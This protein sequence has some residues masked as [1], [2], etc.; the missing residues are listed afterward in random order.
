M[1]IAVL[2]YAT[3]HRKTYDVLCRLKAE[4]YD[5]V[6]VF[7]FPLTYQ[8]KVLPTVRHR[9]DM[10]YLVPDTEK[11]CKSFGYRYMKIESYVEASGQDVYLVGGA[12]IIPQSFV[13]TH[14]I[15]NAHPGYI[16]YARG[17]D[18]L[19][20]AV[21]E[22][23]PVGVTTHLLGPEVDAGWVIERRELPLKP[24]ETFFELGMRVYCN[25]IEMLVE[26]L[27]KLNEPHDFIEAGGSV[28]HR[29]MPHELEEEM[30]LAYQRRQRG[31][32][33]DPIQG[34]ASPVQSA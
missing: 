24:N 7:A 33:D 34:F 22:G 18:A 8:K 5:D 31:G 13:D 21:L 3:P 4:G 16:P 30:L 9:P 10:S 2:T 12:G 20:W 32:D 11:T 28:V 23:L 29:R 1:R 15:V 17:L 26:A 6:V 19:K 14:I 27:V 25:E